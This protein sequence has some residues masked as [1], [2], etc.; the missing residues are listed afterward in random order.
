MLRKN[1][2]WTEER[3]NHT[4]C[5]AEIFADCQPDLWHCPDFLVEPEDEIVRERVYGEV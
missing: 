3:V 1:A 2:D 4:A 5:A